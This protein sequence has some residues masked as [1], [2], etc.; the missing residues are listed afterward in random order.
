MNETFRQQFWEKVR[1]VLRHRMRRLGILGTD[2]SKR[3]EYMK[4]M[5][6]VWTYNEQLLTDVA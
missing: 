4:I 1:D 5:G 6:S 2:R 3:S